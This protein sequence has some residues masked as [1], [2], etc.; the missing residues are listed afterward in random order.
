MRSLP[1][2]P[3]R[4]SA[5]Q[6]LIATFGT[7]VFSPVPLLAE[8]VADSCGKTLQD[9]FIWTS[10]EPPK[11]AQYV[12]FRK[13]LSLGQKPSKA[14]L[15]LFAD[16]RYVLWINAR[17]VERGP[18]RF[19]PKGP[20]IRY[21]GRGGVS[22][23]GRERPGC[24][25]SPLPRRSEVARRHGHQRA[26][27]VAPA[28]VDGVSGVH[29]AGRQDVA[30]HYRHELAIS[31]R[32]AVP[33]GSRP[34]LGV[35]TGA[36]FPT[37]STRDAGTGIGRGA[38]YDDSK[39]AAAVRTPGKSWGPL[40][41][42]LE[43]GI[44]LLKE[45]PVTPLR[46]LGPKP[47]TGVPLVD[48]LPVTLKAGEELLVDP[49]R[50]ILAYVDM[51]FD[52]DEGS[53]FTLS[54][55]QQYYSQGNKPTGSLSK[56]RYTAR[57]GMQRYTSMDVFGMRYLR[58]RCDS[59]RFRVDSIKLTSRNYPFEVVGRFSC[60]DER[61]NA[62]WKIGLDTMLCCSEDAYIDCVCRETGRMAGGR[63]AGRLPGDVGDDGR[64]P[65]RQPRRGRPSSLRRRAA[66]SESAPP[67]RPEPTARR[68][69]QGAS[70]VRPLGQARLHRRLRLSMDP[71]D[72][73]V[74]P[75]Y[76]RLGIR[77]GNA[78]GRRRPIGLV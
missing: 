10:P 26:D 39:W 37:T 73:R 62:I 64:P 70:P 57:Q 49:G 63:R 44:P 17:L 4:L 11:E 5:L 6:I 32:H 65:P 9:A 51:E 43:N 35:R 14:T 52:A 20:A 33:T 68:S 23:E 66:F 12:V 46:V 30:N 78:A 18:C 34:R 45:T 21:A 69:R 61:L 60:N 7:M 75:P 29:F 67:H 55:P 16:S 3:S 31:N 15:H 54:Y 58:L 76:R 36:V 1:Y 28:R 27:H 42:R 22:E 13:R 50:F 47:N 2:M 77:A 38:D 56:S 74:L 48:R 59:G 53:R 24:L 71:G 8:P 19:D 41:S 25:G 40:R 72:S